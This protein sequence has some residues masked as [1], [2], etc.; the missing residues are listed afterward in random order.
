MNGNLISGPIKDRNNL[1][2]DLGGFF[3]TR[4]GIDDQKHF[5]QIKTPSFSPHYSTDG[6][7]RK[8]KNKLDRKSLPQY[9]DDNFIGQ[10][11]DPPVVKQNQATKGRVL[12]PF[13][14]AGGSFD[15][16]SR[17]ENAKYTKYVCVSKL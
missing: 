17:F 11:I 6:E 12:R 8:G 14:V 2:Q 15:P 3:C 9:T 1:G 5:L 16:T 10:F 7:N 13:F 4:R